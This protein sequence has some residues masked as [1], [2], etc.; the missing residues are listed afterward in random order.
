[1]KNKIK[2]LKIKYNVQKKNYQNKTHHI[3][4]ASAHMNDLPSEK[5]YP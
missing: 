2:I 5:K 3:S 1:M 4:H